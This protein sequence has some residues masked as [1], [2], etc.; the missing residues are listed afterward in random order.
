MEV[1]VNVLTA[2]DKFSVSTNQRETIY[3]I[4]QKVKSHL[5]T[6]G[7]LI[8]NQSIIC[9]QGNELQDEQSLKDLDIKSH[10]N[11][12]YLYNLTTDPEEDYIVADIG[13]R[14]EEEPNQL[15]MLLQQLNTDS[16]FCGEI[17]LPDIPQLQEGFNMMMSMG[18][19]PHRCKKALILNL[20][21]K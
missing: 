15:E 21:D 4:K 16:L 17:E 3:S 12:L 8:P 9:Y 6:L 5:R 10:S 7:Y 2:T 1:Y 11:L 19:P 13:N 18:F 20:Y 14:I